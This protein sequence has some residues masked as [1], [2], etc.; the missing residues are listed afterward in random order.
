MLFPAPGQ[1]LDRRQPR[2]HFLATAA[3]GVIHATG[4]Q[5]GE[6]IVERADRLRDRHVVVVQDHQQVHVRGAGVVHRLVRHAGAHRPVADHR[7]DRTLLAFALG[8]D[9]HAERRGNRRR[10]VRSTEGVVL[11]FDA[12]REA[13]NAAPLPQLR[14]AFAAAGQDLVGVGLVT[15]I[16]DQAVARRV[17][18]VMQRDR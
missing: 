8:G 14:H 3:H 10:R 13:G 7:D 5:A 12:A 4:Q 6:I 17:E 15:D 1:L 9:G 16:P 18:D 11:A 2:Q